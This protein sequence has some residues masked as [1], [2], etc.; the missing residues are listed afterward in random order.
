[1]KRVLFIPASASGHVIATFRI[2]K[3]LCD[4][5][6]SVVYLVDT[7]MKNLVQEQGFEVVT[8]NTFLFYNS[9]PM[10]IFDKPNKSFLER[11]ID[12]ISN[13]TLNATIKNLQKFEE[14]IDKIAPDEIILDVF[15]SYNYIL[16]KNKRPM[17]FIQ[18]QL[19][20]YQDALHPPLTSSLTPNN[21][22]LI[23]LD[24]LTYKFIRQWHMFYYLGD[25][26]WGLTKRA[27]KK[28]KRSFDFSLLDW[29]KCFHVGIKNVPE[30]VTSPEVFDFPKEKPLPHQKYIG[31]TTDINRN[32]TLDALYNNW[33]KK[34]EG[35]K[36]AYCSLGTISGGHSDNSADCLKKIA[37]AF[38]TRRDW[39]L[40]IS[41]GDVDVNQLGIVAVNVKLFKRVP[42][43]DVIK[44][45]DLV[46]HHGGINT[47]MECVLFGVPMISFPLSSKWDLNGTTARIVYHNLGLKG[48]IKTITVA[49][50][51]QKIDEITTNPIYKDNIAKMRAVFMQKSKELN[52]TIFEMYK[53]E[54]I[55]LSL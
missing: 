17:T 55:T 3:I 43:L 45:S 20:T 24:W 42:Q 33:V 6:Y 53:G 52:S 47:V 18:T 30:W 25:N 19:S 48:N 51:H 39:E 54:K 21:K 10:A 8:C 31:P 7:N 4:V 50:F 41:C 26:Q 49:E 2:A 34:T 16:L 12:R 37:E 29:N 15:L 23:K 13:I 27:L 38:S 44:R 28:L 36:I 1:M 11:L 5:G 9:D 32:E 35:K 14:A 22:F 40:I 46:I